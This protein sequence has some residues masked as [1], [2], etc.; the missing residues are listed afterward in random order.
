M[1]QGLI[2]MKKFLFRKKVKIRNA[3]IDAII[4]FTLGIFTGVYLGQNVLEIIEF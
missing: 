1:F 4:F 3:I 2:R